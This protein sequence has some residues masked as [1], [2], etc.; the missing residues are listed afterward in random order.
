MSESYDWDDDGVVDETY[1]E[2]YS[3]TYDADGNMLSESV[4][5]DLDGVKCLMK[6]DETYE[7]TYDANGD[8]TSTTYW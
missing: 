8:L 1:G 4:D 2:S 3:Y 5:Y 7:Y 6:I